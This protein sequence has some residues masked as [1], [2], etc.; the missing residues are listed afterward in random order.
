[1]DA[2]HLQGVWTMIT[3]EQA[4]TLPSRGDA[5]QLVQIRVRGRTDMKLTKTWSLGNFVWQLSRNLE[6]TKARKVWKNANA[7]MTNDDTQLAYAW[8]SDS[9][10]NHCLFS[11]IL[12]K[13]F[14]R[15]CRFVLSLHLAIREFCFRDVCRRM[16][17]ISTCQ[18]WRHNTEF[19]LNLPETEGIAKLY[20]VEIVEKNGHEKLRKLMRETSQKSKD[21]CFQAEALE[22][23]I[24]LAIQSFSNCLLLRCSKTKRATT[25]SWRRWLVRTAE[26]D[27]EV[28]LRRFSKPPQCRICLRQWRGK[29]PGWRFA[30]WRQ[31]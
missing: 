7:E 22:K 15:F 3:K 13:I 26:K 6:S 30:S 1:M 12:F 24:D 8:T 17:H 31:L 28:K 27:G 29:A 5:N 16:C 4:S 21:A 19:M 9:F 2:K 20:E 25:S 23:L 14:S 10:S 11:L 18:E